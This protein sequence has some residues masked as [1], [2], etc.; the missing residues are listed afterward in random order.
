M[1]SFL[2]LGLIPGTNI[3]ITFQI[4]LDMVLVMI[5]IAGIIWLYRRRHSDSHKKLPVLFS[6]VGRIYRNVYQS[7]V[8]ELKAYIFDRSTPSSAEF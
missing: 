8:A 5:D 1:Y 4:W 2:L 3:Q 7:F 6:L